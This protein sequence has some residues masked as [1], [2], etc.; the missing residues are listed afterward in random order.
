MADLNIYAPPPYSTVLLSKCARTR[1]RER[2]QEK[3]AAQPSPYSGTGNTRT[4]TID[5]I[6]GNGTLSISIAAGS[7]TNWQS[8]PA[9]AAGPSA[10]VI[11]DNAVPTIEVSPPSAMVTNN[12]PVSYTV[13]YAGVDTVTLSEG[14]ITLVTTGTATGTVSVAGGKTD[15]IL[16]R[17]I[18]LDNLSGQG[19]I[20]ILIAAGTAHDTAGNP[21][22]ALE[23]S[24][25]VMV[26]YNPN[27]D[28][29]GDGISNVEEGVND[30]D[31][32]GILNFLDEDSDGDGVPD[33]TERMFGSNPYDVLNPTGLPLMWWPMALALLLAGGFGARRFVAVRN[34]K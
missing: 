1:P 17:T 29:D 16:E 26:G 20:G 33:A 9:P 10:E 27:G 25:P 3:P 13:T 15:T 28:E 18:I 11:V 7:A 8:D 34:T 23:Y 31:G 21:A 6:T 19:T 4:V 5:S 2:G 24:V 12:G 22:P 14:D 32:D 30:P